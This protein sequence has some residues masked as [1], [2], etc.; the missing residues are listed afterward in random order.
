MKTLKTVFSPEA[1]AA[2]EKLRAYVVPGAL[3]VQGHGFGALSLC[4]EKVGVF[5][6]SFNIGPTAECTPKQRKY[7]YHNL[8]AEVASC[9]FVSPRVHVPK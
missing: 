3:R 2:R 4:T 9:R 5:S 7:R 8:T 6:H 1:L